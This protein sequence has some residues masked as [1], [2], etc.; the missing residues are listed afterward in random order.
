MMIL[1]QFFSLG[2]I[3]SWIEESL[4]EFLTW[5]FVPSYQ[6]FYDTARDHVLKKPWINPL[7]ITNKSYENRYNVSIIWAFIGSLYGNQRI[8]EIA[9]TA[10]KSQDPNKH[11]F[12]LLAEYLKVPVRDLALSWAHACLTFSFFKPEHQPYLQKY[13]SKKKFKQLA[14][15]NYSNENMA[16]ITKR[17]ERYGF[18]VSQPIVLNAP[19][20]PPKTGQWEIRYIHNN[21][22]SLSPNLSE[23]CRILMI[24]ML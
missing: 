7:S 14:T 18:E 2:G 12:E 15:F 6:A 4:C 11:D 3:Q 5:M 20:T 13:F 1:H 24:R 22:P 17:T 8:G 16:E 19:I 23:S 10:F 9:N 21:V